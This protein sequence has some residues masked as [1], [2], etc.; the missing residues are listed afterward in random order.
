MTIPPPIPK[1]PAHRPL[2]MPL[3]MNIRSITVPLMNLGLIVNGRLEYL[4]KERGVYY[5]RFLDCSIF[6]S[7]GLLFD[8]YGIEHF[9]RFGDEYFELDAGV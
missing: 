5:E 1:S 7:D 2:S 6:I 9:G 4:A 3:R 8:E